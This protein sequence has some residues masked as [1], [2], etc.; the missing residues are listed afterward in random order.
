[1]RTT[2]VIG[3]LKVELD[4]VKKSPTFSIE[5]KT[6]RYTGTVPRDD[7]G[8]ESA[9]LIE[10]VNN[11]SLLVGEFVDPD[12]K[13]YAMVVNKNMHS[14]VAVGL[15]F[16]AQGRIMLVSQFNRG[17]VPLRGEQV[18]LAPGC[19]VLLTVE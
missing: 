6:A 2:S 3:R 4:W 18:W 19:G 12:G 16:K 7:K 5:R 8:I 1:M 9:Q 13:P 11:P 15:Q 10:S 14:S 17:L